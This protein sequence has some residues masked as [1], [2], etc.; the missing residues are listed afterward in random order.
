[1][2]SV[3]V[4]AIG[5]PWCDDANFRHSRVT[6]SIQQSLIALDVLH[7]MANL[8]GA[9]VGAQK[10]TAFYVE[11]VVHRTGGMVFWRIECREVEPIG[12]DFW[13][14]RDFKTHRAKN[15]FDAL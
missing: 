11:G 7:R 9:G 13:T 14:L 1:M 4:D 6:T 15:G 3:A 12:F 2:R 10:I 8:H 5:A